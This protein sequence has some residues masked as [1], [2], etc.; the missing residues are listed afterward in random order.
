MKKFMKV[1]HRIWYS[2]LRIISKY[3]DLQKA[4]NYLL[5]E[6][7]SGKLNYRTRELAES[8][9]PE[10]SIQRHPDYVDVA[11]LVGPND[12]EVI[13]RSSDSLLK[14]ISKI[15]KSYLIAPRAAH[16]SLKRIVSKDFELICDEDLLSQELLDSV[17]NLVPPTKHGWI[18]QQLLK[19]VSTQNLT[20]GGILLLDAD[21]VLL[22][23][24]DWIDTSGVQNLNISVEFHEPYVEHFKRFMKAIGRKEIFE[25]NIGVSFVTHYQLMQREIVREIFEF[26]GREFTEG[27]E[28]WIKELDFSKTESAGSEWHTYGTFLAMRHPEKIRLSQWRNTG[29]PREYL[30]GQDNFLELPSTYGKF[31]SVSLHHYL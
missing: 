8:L 16:M 19:F 27:L 25:K 20:N 9:L 17:R 14:N 13:R 4:Q 1:K 18:R 11:I 7:K 12:Q 26:E 30:L 28:I 24:Q 29:V 31:N 6:N 5:K 3:F 10:V 22:K 23:Q 15:N 21:T 2:G